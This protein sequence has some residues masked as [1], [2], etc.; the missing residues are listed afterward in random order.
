MAISPQLKRQHEALI[1]ALA[2]WNRERQLGF[3]ARGIREAYAAVLK[4][5]AAYKQAQ[6]RAGIRV[7]EES[8]EEPNDDL[9]GLSMFYR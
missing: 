2:V 6:A 4:A 5:K 9:D 1:Y 3:S 7:D 8:D